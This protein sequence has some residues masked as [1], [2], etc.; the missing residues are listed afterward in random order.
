MFKYL[1]GFLFLGLFIYAVSLHVPAFHVV[2]LNALNVTAVFLHNSI[3]T[4]HGFLGGSNNV[5]L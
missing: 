4:I 2:V 5:A 1:F 3:S